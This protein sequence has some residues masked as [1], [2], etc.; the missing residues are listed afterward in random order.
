MHCDDRGLVRRTRTRMRMRCPEQGNIRMTNE[1]QI[2]CAI[3][4]TSKPFLE[5][6]V[7]QTLE[8][9]SKHPG[10]VI[11]VI[12]GTQRRI[13]HHVYR[14][15]KWKDNV[16]LLERDG[17]TE[18]RCNA[19]APPANNLVELLRSWSL[20]VSVDRIGYSLS[21]GQEFVPAFHIYNALGRPRWIQPTVSPGECGDRFLVRCSQPRGC[22]LCRSHAAVQPASRGLRAGAIVRVAV[23]ISAP[24]VHRGEPD[25]WS[26]HNRRA[27][28]PGCSVG[29]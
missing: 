6:H 3:P 16:L 13:L 25:G 19:E 4:S 15:Q 17:T 2:S 12:H 1:H 26:R 10:I 9:G 28:G 11:H 22:E 7:A 24:F 23:P 14:I 21:D 18:P 8:V 5:P 29:P 20:D 27:P